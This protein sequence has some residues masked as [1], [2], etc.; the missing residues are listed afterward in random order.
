MIASSMKDH[1]HPPQGRCHLYC[2]AGVEVG[3]VDEL[4]PPLTELLQAL[5][6]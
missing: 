4:R 1:R 5:K 6:K 3:P 2:G